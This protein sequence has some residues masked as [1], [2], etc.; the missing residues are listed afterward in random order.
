MKNHHEYD[1]AESC[2]I[3]R[4]PRTMSSAELEALGRPRVSRGDAIRAKCIDCSGGNAAEARRCAMLD[5]PLW[6][7]RMGTDPF[8]EPKSEEQRQL[9]SQM[10]KA[11]R[12][13][14]GKDQDSIG[15]GPSL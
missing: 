5:C 9:A 15:L 3:G 12:A 7:F 14:L 11:R 10:A 4:D 1:T 13:A 6:P 8:R 2:L